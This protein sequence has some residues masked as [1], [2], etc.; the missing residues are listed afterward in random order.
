MAGLRRMEEPSLLR[1]RVP[2]SSL[3]L[4]VE[5]C[6]FTERG[7]EN[8]KLTDGIYCRPQFTL[9]SFE[10]GRPLGK[11]KFGRVYMARTKGEHQFILALKCLNK[12]ELVK[13]KVERQVRREI[14][15]Q[16]HLR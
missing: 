3:S 9:S 16:S 11:G 8:W 14:E 6:K 2:R 13:A 7:R 10:I 1:E 12:E 15:I 5:I 4:P